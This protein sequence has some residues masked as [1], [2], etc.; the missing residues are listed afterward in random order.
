MGCFASKLG[1]YDMLFKSDKVY[2][3][4]RAK[5]AERAAKAKKVE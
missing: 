1:L 5:R 2:N 3:N 4:W